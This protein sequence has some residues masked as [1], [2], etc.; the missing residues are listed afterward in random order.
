MTEQEQWLAEERKKQEIE[1]ENIPYAKA[2]FSIC[3][4]CE[5]L[6]KPVMICKICYCFM[7]GKT[8]FKSQECPLGKWNAIDE[9][10]IY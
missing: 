1:I 6:I 8:K 3:K 9:D 2:R 4:Q 10:E 7:P 5:E